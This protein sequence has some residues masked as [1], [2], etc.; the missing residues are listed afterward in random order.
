MCRI[1]RTFVFA[2]QAKAPGLT[3]SAHANN[4]HDP[5]ACPLHAADVR[6][7]SARAIGERSLPARASRGSAAV[8]TRRR[9]PPRYHPHRTYSVNCRAVG[10]L[11][12]D[13]LV[14]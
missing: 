1:L 8:A 6:A 4:R 9:D 5:P 13:P 14:R 3:R 7:E 11:A 10:G 12:T 2:G